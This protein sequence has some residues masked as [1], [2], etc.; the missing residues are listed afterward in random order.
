MN[1]TFIKRLMLPVL[2]VIPYKFSY[3]LLIFLVGFSLIEILFLTKAAHSKAKNF[4]YGIFE[5][6][7]ISLVGGFVI[8]DLGNNSSGQASGLN[9]FATLLLA[10]YIIVFVV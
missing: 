9:I 8:A 1:L 5:L 2:V 10:V 7:C 4:I 6:A 3:S